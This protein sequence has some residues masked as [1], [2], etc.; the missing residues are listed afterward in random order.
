[1]PSV[2]QDQQKAMAIAEHDPSKLYKR[3]KGLLG[4]NHKQLHDFAS[5]P[6]KGLPK[7]AKPMMGGAIKRG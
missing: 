4:M 3:N 6:D 1:M 5:T 2:S 7:K